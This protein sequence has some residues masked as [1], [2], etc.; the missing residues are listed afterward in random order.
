[1]AIDVKEVGEVFV[2]KDL[3]FSTYEEGEEL[4]HEATYGFYSSYESARKATKMLEEKNWNL[5]RG[6]WH[7]YS[8]IVY[9]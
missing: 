8:E 1:M 5:P 6:D 2:V 3:K 9:E 7:I 4:L